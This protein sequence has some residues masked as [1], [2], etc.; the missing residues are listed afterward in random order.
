M[1]A[2]G[3]YRLEI[4]YRPPG[5]LHPNLALAAGLVG[6]RW[7]TNP[8]RYRKPLQAPRFSGAYEGT[9]KGQGAKS[10]ILTF[11]NGCVRA[12]L[13]TR[14]SVG[15]LSSPGVTLEKLHSSLQTTKSESPPLVFA[16]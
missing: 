3:L 8:R 5:D 13:R 7:V 15:R 16:T 6:D 11:A 10:A 9:M 4:A 1:R 14:E 12:R 2:P